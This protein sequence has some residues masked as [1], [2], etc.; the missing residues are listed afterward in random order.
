LT[1][2]SHLSTKIIRWKHYTT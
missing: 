2:T 1:V